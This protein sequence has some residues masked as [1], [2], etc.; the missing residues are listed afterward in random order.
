VFI[1]KIDLNLK[2]KVVLVAQNDG[3]TNGAVR[4]RTGSAFEPRSVHIIVV[5]KNQILI[6]NSIEN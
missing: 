3:A 5:L 4:E 6:Q 2:K 1:K